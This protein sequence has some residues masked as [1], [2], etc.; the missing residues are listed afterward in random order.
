VADEGSTKTVLVVEPDPGCR[1]VAVEILELRGYEV[2]EAVDGH[3][4]IELFGQ[5]RFA[6]V[7]IEVTLPGKRGV[8]VIAAM[9]RRDPRV[10]IVAV[11]AYGPL[12]VNPHLQEAVQAGADATIDK[13]FG[14]ARLR[15]L[16]DKAW[17]D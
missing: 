17:P 3:E 8:D 13:P 4:A 11:S 10:R 6:C 9:R 14:P 16:L 12:S 1:H 7:L 2:V 15:G 5:R